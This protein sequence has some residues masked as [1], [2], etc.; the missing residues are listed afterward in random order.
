MQSFSGSLSRRIIETEEKRLKNEELVNRVKEQVIENRELDLAIGRLLLT[1]WEQ[2][3]R[4]AGR[5]CQS[6]VE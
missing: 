3:Q 2:F 4:S 1:F 5:R 6:A